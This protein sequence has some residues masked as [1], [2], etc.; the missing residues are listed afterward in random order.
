VYVILAPPQENGGWI[1]MKSWMRI[2]KFVGEA[3]EVAMAAPP[4]TTRKAA[5]RIQKLVL[6]GDGQ[7]PAYCL[8]LSSLPFLCK[9]NI[10]SELMADNA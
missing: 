6:V 4:P 3:L 7:N 9:T 8:L 5:F 1:D 10:L 2:Q